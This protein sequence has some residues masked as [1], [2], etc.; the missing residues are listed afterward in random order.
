MNNHKGS[1]SATL[2]SMTHAIKA[3]K[4]LAAAAIPA[5]IIKTEPA[6]SLHGCSYGIEFSCNQAQN[7]RK[8][9]ST[10]GISVKKWN[11][12]D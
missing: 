5:N 10:G 1:C 8:V 3:Q 4:V 9:L 11:I 6:S 12:T 7:V 2:A